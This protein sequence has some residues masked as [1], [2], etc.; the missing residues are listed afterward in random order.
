MN[1]FL[2]ILMTV[3]PVAWSA[4]AE[5][6]H[7]RRARGMTTRRVVYA[8]PPAYA[9]APAP[10]RVP[11]GS[12]QP[13]Y[14]AAP[15][16]AAVATPSPPMAPAA[17]P[18]QYQYDAEPGGPTAYYYTYDDSGKL[19]VVQWMDWLFRGGRRAGMPAPP[20]PIVGR[21]RD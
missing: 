20:L 12:W 1:K 4:T 19:I 6:C 17:V 5:A 2:A 16:P 18:P 15:A 11:A 10:A 14:Q 21:L 8:C 9:P 7:G 3:L 13:S